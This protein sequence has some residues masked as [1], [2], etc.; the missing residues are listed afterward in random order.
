MPWSDVQRARLI[1]ERDILAKYF[2]DNVTW[3][4]INENTKVQL[5]L[6][7]NSD[8]K[9]TLR[10]Y[11]LPDFPNSCPHMAVVS[12]SPLV[13]QNGEPLEHLSRRFHTQ[14]LTTDGYTKLCH[15]SPD[16]WTS[17]NTLFQVIVKGR[18]WIEAYEWYL[19]NGN[20]ID[21]YLRHQAET[22][23]PTRCIIS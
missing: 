18:L 6:K 8:K 14:G 17:E 12:P 4:D 7:T 23:T 10:L 11:L 1:V 19:E 22:E 9:Y 21:T 15:C 20:P 2:G 3:I 13:K 5:Q 16:L